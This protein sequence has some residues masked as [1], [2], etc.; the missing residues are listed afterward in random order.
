[1]TLSPG[2]GSGPGTPAA[3]A[4]HRLR[5][6]PSGPDL[7]HGATLRGTRAIDT[8]SGA[9]TPRQ[10]PST[11]DSASLERNCE[12][13]GAA[14]SPP[15]TIH[16]EGYRFRHTAGMDDLTTIDLERG[17]NEASDL[18]P[19]ENDALLAA[20]SWDR[21]FWTVLDEGHVED[22]VAVL[23]HRAGAGDR[24]GWEIHALT[25]LA[26]ENSGRTTDGEACARHDGWVYVV[27]SHYGSKDG[28]LQAKR[29]WLARFHEQSIDREVPETDVS[30]QIERNQFRL[31][32][33]IND[34]LDE[35]DVVPIVP[36]DAVR[37]RFIAQTLERGE[38]KGKSWAH[39]LRD[40]DVPSNV[41]AAAFRPSGTLLLGLRFPTSADGEP[42][43]VELAGV[44]E[45]FED[46]EAWPRVERVWV[47]EG[48]TPPGTLTG[49]RALS[50]A[51]EGTFDAIIGSIDATGKGS[52][53]LDDHP[54]GAEVESAHWRFTLP[55]GGTIDEAI[56]VRGEHVRTLD[57]L[58]NVE[59]LS[60]EGGRAH[61]VTD[62]D[63]RIQ[64]R[65]E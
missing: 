50:H 25:C 34:A 45:M 6:L 53:L 37:D 5:L 13:Q 36:G 35:A 14:T 33:V 18:L 29:A 54:A 31:H 7:V 60:V 19:V 26:G 17:G 15:S 55:A 47:L 16:R 61:Y 63:E 12:R 39:R 9:L 22:S 32:R 46:A 2:D 52:V 28:P 62:E 65:F 3:H 58:R 64:L 40:R 42:L 30:L 43:I 59:G 57:G 21:G 27:G 41:E 11:G 23:G 51:G 56:R 8:A 20:H 10:D 24:E 49:F 44:P 48:A 1:M 4:R 38:R